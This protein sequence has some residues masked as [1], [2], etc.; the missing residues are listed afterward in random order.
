LNEAHNDGTVMKQKPRR[1]RKRRN[2]R[3][4]EWRNECIY[5]CVCIHT[6]VCICI[7]RY[8]TYIHM[9]VCMYGVWVCM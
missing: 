4:S 1:R 2:I 9:Y 5:L 7:Y 3:L 6:Y 8:I